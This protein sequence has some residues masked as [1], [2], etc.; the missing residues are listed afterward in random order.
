M[1]P[2]PCPD[3]AAEVRLRIV[4]SD[5]CLHCNSQPTTDVHWCTRLIKTVC[6]CAA[7][8]QAAL[9]HPAANHHHHEH[10]GQQP[11]PPTNGALPPGKSRCCRPNSG[12]LAGVTGVTMC[13]QKG[14]SPASKRSGDFCMSNNCAPA[15]YVSSAAAAPRRG[16]GCL[17][18]ARIP[19]EKLQ[20]AGQ[21]CT[22]HVCRRHHACC[23]HAV[24][25]TPG[26]LHGRR[27]HHVRRRAHPLWRL[28]RLRGCWQP[29][30]IHPGEL[31][32]ALGII[33]TMR[34]VTENVYAMA[35]YRIQPSWQL[36]CTRCKLFSPFVCSLKWTPH[37]R[38]LRLQSSALAA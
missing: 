13:C 12:S 38:C 31:T 34:A 7:G 8:V 9:R 29:G 35:P 24:L 6:L 10:P 1:D 4:A 23:S 30:H 2:W 21:L 19:A 25:R 37:T 27:L 18:L 11:R 16:S 20:F 17:Q 26:A 3:V 5:S 22:A 28:C 14:V 36:D 33:T 15:K 32:R